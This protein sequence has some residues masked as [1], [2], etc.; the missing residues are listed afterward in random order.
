MATLQSVLS[1]YETNASYREDNDASK[2]LAFISAC[3]KLL[4]KLPS[5]SGKSGGAEVEIDVTLVEKQLLR[6]EAWLD[7]HRSETD[8][9]T[10]PSVIHPD[11]TNF[12][13]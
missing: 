9:L 11:F 13:C 3:T 6:A 7:S 4:T 2:A 8:L 1:D 5:R 10:N 12:R